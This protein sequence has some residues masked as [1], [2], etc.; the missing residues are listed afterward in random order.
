MKKADNQKWIEFL[1]E[2]GL[3]ST[4]FIILLGVVFSIISAISLFIAG[5]WEI[6]NA[7]N[8]TVRNID[9]L[10]HSIHHE[11]VPGIINAIDL[12]LIGVV[13]MIFGFGIYELFISKIDVARSDSD[14]TILEI[15][16]LDELKN[17]INT[18]I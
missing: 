16:D 6:Y 11:L 3:W 15:K 18:L 12:Y 13:L 2:K 17:K 9:N 5:S 1:F 4:R 7:I 8:H 10:E 14:I